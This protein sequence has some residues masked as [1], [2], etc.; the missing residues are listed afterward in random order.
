MQVHCGDGVTVG[1]AVSLGVSVAGG[2]YVLLGVSEGTYDGVGV[3][4]LLQ[5]QVSDGVGVA[6]S[7]GGGVWLQPQSVGGDE[8]GGLVQPQCVGGVVGG[9]VLGGGVVGGAVVGGA[10]VGG[11]VLGGVDGVDVDGRGA[12]WVRLGVGAGC[13]LEVV[14]VVGTDEAA[15]AGACGWSH[16]KP[17]KRWSPPFSLDRPTFTPSRR[18]QP[19]A[20]VVYWNS[21]K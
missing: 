14:G 15:G 17:A 20:F 6:V 1:V 8:D 9:D 13:V 5:P 19:P 12:G 4:V 7:D 11:L 2:V 18:K 10:V 21:R 16:R 3:E